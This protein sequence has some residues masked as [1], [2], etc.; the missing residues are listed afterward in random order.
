MTN[1]IAEVARPFSLP[2]VRRNYSS[3][4]HTFVSNLAVKISRDQRIAELINAAKNNPIVISQD[5][6]SG[7]RMDETEIFKV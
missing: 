2:I 4:I 1:Y 6:V 7:V 3:Y 5:T